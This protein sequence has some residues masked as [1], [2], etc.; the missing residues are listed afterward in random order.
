[1]WTLETVLSEGAWGF[2]AD[3]VIS[4]GKLYMSSLRFGFDENAQPR[5]EV[6][7]VIRNLP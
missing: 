6:R 7:V 4:A 1:M 5:N 2:F 3:L